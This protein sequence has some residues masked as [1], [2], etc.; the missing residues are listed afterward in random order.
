MRCINYCYKSSKTMQSV[1]KNIIIHHKEK[2][3]CSPQL[4][5]YLLSKELSPD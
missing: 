2:P 4:V 5:A 3:V 1:D